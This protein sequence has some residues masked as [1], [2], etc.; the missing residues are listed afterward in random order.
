MDYSNANSGGANHKSIT[1]VQLSHLMAIVIG[2]AVIPTL[3][4]NAFRLP[5]YILPRQTEDALAAGE[6]T[7]S[8]KTAL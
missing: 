8:L 4:A 3:I 2:S 5:H 7:D 6:S 1:Q